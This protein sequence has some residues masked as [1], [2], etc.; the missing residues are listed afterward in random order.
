[1]G[2]VIIMG[3]LNCRVGQEVDYIESDDG[4]R[5]LNIPSQLDHT[6]LED[7]IGKSSI[8]T[9]NR[10]SEDHVTN[11]NGKELLQL[12]R[13]NKLYILNS[14]VGPEPEGCFTCHTARGNSFVEHRT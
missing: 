7:I 13:T 4:D 3:D 2:R 9:K 6:N 12:C 10:T 14:R 5:F 1:M 8:I 11:E